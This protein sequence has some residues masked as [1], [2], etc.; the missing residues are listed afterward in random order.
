MLLIKAMGRAGTVFVV[1]QKPKIAVSKLLYLTTAML[2]ADLK[3]GPVI[4]GIMR[5]AAAVKW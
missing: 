1:I 4:E 2:R 5:L 3:V